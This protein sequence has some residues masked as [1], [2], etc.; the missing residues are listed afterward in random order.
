VGQF[1]TI[2]KRNEKGITQPYEVMDSFDFM[3]ICANCGDHSGVFIF[4]K[5]I[6]LQQG[7]ILGNNSKG[8][9]GIRVYPSWD[10]ALNKQAEK[11]QLWQLDYFVTIT[12]ENITDIDKARRILSVPKL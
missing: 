10:T 5:Q 1:V 12:P 2:W 4:P 7:I 9:R 6:L 8:K 11:T 3:I